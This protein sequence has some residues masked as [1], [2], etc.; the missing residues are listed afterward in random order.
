MNKEVEIEYEKLHKKNLSRRKQFS[1]EIENSSISFNI[2]KKRV[3]SRLN[4]F[5]PNR[6]K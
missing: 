1:K 4:R 3:D 5:I 2:S 6:K